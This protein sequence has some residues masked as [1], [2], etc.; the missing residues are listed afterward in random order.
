M[1][2][3]VD[4]YESMVK[5]TLQETD[6]DVNPNRIIRTVGCIIYLLKPC[7]NISLYQ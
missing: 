6:L 5:L 1:C 3:C 4:G 7:S 2:G